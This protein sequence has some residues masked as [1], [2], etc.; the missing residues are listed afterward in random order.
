MRT[1]SSQILHIGAPIFPYTDQSLS[2]VIEQSDKYSIESAGQVQ[3]YTIANHLMCLVKRLPGGHNKW[4]FIDTKELNEVYC[5]KLK[6]LEMCDTLFF[7]LKK[8]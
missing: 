4:K 7:I 1:V 5:E 2:K 3:R 6:E 8:R